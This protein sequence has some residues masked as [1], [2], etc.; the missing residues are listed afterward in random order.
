MAAGEVR[1]FVL[2]GA[3]AQPMLITL[4]PPDQGL[5][6]SI[7]TQGGTSMLSPSTGQLTWRGSLPRTEDYYVGVYGGARD[8]DFTLTVQLA[9]R[10]KFKEGATSATVAGKTLSGSAVAFSVLGIKGD[11]MIVSISGAGRDAALGIYG[12]VDG[13]PYLSSTSRK[14][15]F[16]FKVPSTQD[17]IIE[18]VPRAG[19]AVSYVLD[20][21]FP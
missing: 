17:Y 13:Q 11:T 9:L 4:V 19:R 15:N 20:V 8:Q 12:Y 7:R 18:I 21:Q 5:G 6:L 3:Q 14:T 10:I 16:K 1:W 2:R